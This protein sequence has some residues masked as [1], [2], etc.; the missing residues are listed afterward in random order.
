MNT[1]RGF[2]VIRYIFKPYR[3]AEAFWNLLRYVVNEQIL[4]PAAVPPGQELA[5]PHR[6][7]TESVWKG[8][9]ALGSVGSQTASRRFCFP[10]CYLY[11]FYRQNKIQ[12]ESRLNSRFVLYVVVKGSCKSVAELRFLFDLY[13]KSKGCFVFSWQHWIGNNKIS[14]GDYSFEKIPNFPFWGSVTNRN[15][16]MTRNVKRLGKVIEL[17][18]PQKKSND[19]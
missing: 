14:V 5:V 1:W 7:L 11:P 3:S 16:K 6:K 12:G 17:V 9:N 4:A 19:I 8:V 10:S 13:Y 18:V 15:T 2:S